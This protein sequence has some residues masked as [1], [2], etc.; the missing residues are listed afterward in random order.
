[1]SDWLWAQGFCLLVILGAAA[2]WLRWY[3]VTIHRPARLRSF[4]YRI[5]AVRDKV[6]R[7]VADGQ[8]REE[9]AHWQSLYAFVNESARVV[10]VAKMQDGFTFVMDVLKQSPPP[11]EMRMAELPEPLRLAISELCVAVFS[12]C[13]EGSLWLRLFWPYPMIGKMLLDK[14]HPIEMRNFRTWE[15]RAQAGGYGLQPA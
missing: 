13:W 2:A 8:V 5:F 14:R 1:M 12:I 4:Q 9:D 6:I 10:N 11:E 7:L 15:Q 3:F